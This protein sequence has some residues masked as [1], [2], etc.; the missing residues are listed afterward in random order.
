VRFEKAVTIGAPREAVWAFL[1]D[2]PRLVA[3]VPGCQEARVVE[4]GRRYAAT[5]KE[6]V[7][8]IKVEFPLEIEVLET[9]PPEFLRGRAEGRDPKVDG[10]VKVALDLRLSEAGPDGTRLEFATDLV[11]LGKLGT[12]GHGII[13]RKADEVVGQFASAVKARLEGSGERAGGV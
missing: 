10:L 9:R 12:M 3:C 4:E 1:W 6:R 2:L 5:V 7:G 13:V 11:L 8:P